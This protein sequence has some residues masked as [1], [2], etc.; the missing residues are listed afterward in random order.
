MTYVEKN[1]LHQVTYQ[2]TFERIPE[3]NHSIV[4]VARKYSKQK[5][6]EINS[7]HFKIHTGEKPF[8]CELCGKGFL[9]SS[10]PSR[11]LT[12]SNT[13]WIETV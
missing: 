5:I 7:K 12:S 8:K 1:S 10:H 9:R 2:R 11:N 4:N 3:P 13:H 6:P